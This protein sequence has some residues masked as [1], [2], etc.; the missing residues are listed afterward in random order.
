LW[1]QVASGTLTSGVRC[2]LPRSKCRLRRTALGTRGL[3]DGIWEPACRRLRILPKAHEGYLW[4]EGFICGDCWRRKLED[5]AFVREMERQ[6]QG[7]V[8]TATGSG[9]DGGEV[10]E[11]IPP[12]RTQRERRALESLRGLSVGDALGARWEG[13]AFDAQT[14]I[15]NLQPDEGPAVWTDDTQMALSVVEVLYQRGCIDQDRLAAAF[16]RR[17]EPWRGYGAGMHHLLSRLRE[18]DDW[19]SARFNIFPEGSFGN[20]SAM[21]VAPLG[22]F[23]FEDSIETV[24]REAALSAEVTHA[25]PEGKAGAVAVATAAWLAARSRGQGPP[26][27]IEVCDAPLEPFLAVTKQTRLAARLPEGTSLDEA[28]T[29]LGNGS[30][31]SCQDTVPLALWI[32][33]AHMDDYETAV[34]W[35]IAAGGD[36]D[37]LAAIVGGIVA[38]RLGPASFP[39]E[40][41][42]VERVPVQD[43]SVADRTPRPE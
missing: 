39:I 24:V 33:F 6:L 1:R 32:A 34:Q 37:T 31:V 8:A 11:R 4:P 21:R 23:C 18:G 22:A 7:L 14:A 35:G 38:A 26:R 5:P 25:H 43:E 27:I 16:A 41:P 36:T 30:H 9:S 42:W 3:A 40:R 10:D 19:R 12:A 17:Y 20:G 29:R 2:L 13:A 28:V 15:G